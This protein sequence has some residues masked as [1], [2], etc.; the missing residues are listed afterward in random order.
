MHSTP[1]VSGAWPPEPLAL[2][3]GTGRRK[4]G[5]RVVGVGGGVELAGLA[6]MVTPGTSRPPT[7]PGWSGGTELTESSRQTDRG[8]ANSL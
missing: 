6:G 5:H 4:G 7:T 3:V 2:G 8:L 1:G